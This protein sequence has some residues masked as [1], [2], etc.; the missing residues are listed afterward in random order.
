MYKQLLKF[1]ISS[2]VLRH[3]IGPFVR[4]FANRVD[5]AMVAKVK[6]DRQGTQR[7]LSPRRGSSL[8]V[9]SRTCWPRCRRSRSSR[10]WRSTWMRRS[11][12]WS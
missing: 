2:N 12:P 7:P 1:D 4:D 5:A 10:R 6:Y 9:P 11:T 3:I 8:Q